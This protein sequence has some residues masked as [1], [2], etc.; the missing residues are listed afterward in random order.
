MKSNARKCF[1]WPGMGDQLQNCCDQCCWCTEIAPSNKRS[2]C[3]N[4]FILVSFPAS[5]CWPI[6][7]G[8]MSIPHLCWLFLG[9]TEIVFT[10]SDTAAQTI[11]LLSFSNPDIFLHVFHPACTHFFIALVY[12]PSACTVRPIYLLSSV[13]GTSTPPIFIIGNA[14][15][16]IL[17][18]SHAT[19]R[20]E[21]FA[22]RNNE[23]MNK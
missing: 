5:C 2:H 13:L 14:H 15:L 22:D 9:W 17:L 20:V 23:I 1:F 7:H 8:R 11:C 21:S 16:V 18:F 6:S 4:P 10:H 19:L 3:L 12:P